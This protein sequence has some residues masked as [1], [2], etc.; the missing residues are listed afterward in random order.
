MDKDSSFLITYLTSSQ[1][2]NVTGGEE[3]ERED[4]IGADTHTL[5]EQHRFVNMFV[6]TQ[7]PCD[8]ESPPFQS[9]A[10]FA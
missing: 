9:F 1:N 2:L 10:P 8:Y 6:P 3:D 4:E 5:I 7:P